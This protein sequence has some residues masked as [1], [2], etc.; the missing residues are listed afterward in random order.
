VVYPS[1]DHWLL[2]Q[3]TEARN[4]IGLS[5]RL[6]VLRGSKVVIAE[7]LCA[8]YD[9]VQYT[10]CRQQDNGACIEMTVIT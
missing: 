9:T 1:L 7:A 2:A 8:L 10:Q 4:T 5:W 3:A 6:A